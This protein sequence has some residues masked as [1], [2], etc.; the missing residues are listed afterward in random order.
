MTAMISLISRYLGFRGRRARE[1][2]GKKKNAFFS[3]TLY[4]VQ[5]CPKKYGVF[6]VFFIVFCCRAAKKFLAGPRSHHGPRSKSQ[7][8]TR[9]GA[10]N[11]TVNSNDVLL[12]ST[13]LEPNH[14]FL[15]LNSRQGRVYINFTVRP[16]HGKM[17]GKKRTR[18]LRSQLEDLLP[19]GRLSAEQL[20][21]VIEGFWTW[22]LDHVDDIQGFN[23]VDFTAM[24]WR[25]R[26]FFMAARKRRPSSAADTDDAAED[27]P[28]GPGPGGPGGP[29]SPGQ[30]IAI[31]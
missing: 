28:S 20:G 9:P 19:N 12:I 18:D 5:K 14:H 2:G 17:S 10:W 11:S 29:G 6:F 22:I 30:P 27:A 4:F 21:D 8:R 3:Q 23:R 16:E 1:F 24:A 13:E 15:K 31:H 7:P 25:L 26:N